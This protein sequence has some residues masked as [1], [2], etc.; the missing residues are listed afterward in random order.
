MR[1][2]PRSPDRNLDNSPLRGLTTDFGSAKKAV[3]GIHFLISLDWQERPLRKPRSIQVYAPRSGIATEQASA[4]ASPRARIPGHLPYRK[5]SE[6][7]FLPP[8]RWSGI[9]RHRQF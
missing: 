5:G 7:V 9:E 2:Q 3:T 4:H 6:R 8:G 1:G